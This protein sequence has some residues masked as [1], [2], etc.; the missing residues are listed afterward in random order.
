MILGDGD[1]GEFCYV[2]GRR[3]TYKVPKSK[4]TMNPPKKGACC[5]KCKGKSFDVFD[6]YV[7]CTNPACEWHSQKAEKHICGVP[8]GTSPDYK[9]GEGLTLRCANLPPCHLHV[10]TTNTAEK[11]WT[12]TPC[13]NPQH[14]ARGCKAVYFGGSLF[15][16][17]ETLHAMSAPTTNT[18][19]NAG[20]GTASGAPGKGRLVPTNMADKEISMV[21]MTVEPDKNLE[22]EDTSDWQK[23]SFLQHTF[24]L[25]YVNAVSLKNFIA[26]E[27]IQA[28][29][30]AWKGRS[31]YEAGR[32]SRDEELTVKVEQARE[33]ESKWWRDAQKVVYERGKLA[34]I[35]IGNATGAGYKRG[36]EAG[37][38][39]KQAEIREVIEEMK[40]KINIPKRIGAH[41][42]EP[43]DYNAALTDVL[44]KLEAKE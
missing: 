8:I 30:E 33:D 41:F 38:A 24:E 4:P 16:C 19:E 43:D 35:K 10:L 36:V 31:D 23:P 20:N 37:K 1:A 18:A 25:N 44:S 28:R 42:V 2:E 32:A 11:K 29:K 9:T 15:D 34:G 22:W 26:K 39:A 7:D 5:E 14:R 40:L 3:R 12:T 17:F 6:M 21:G 27:L 13:A